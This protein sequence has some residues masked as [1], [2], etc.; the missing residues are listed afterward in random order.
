MSPSS[1][2]SALAVRAGGLAIALAALA[3]CSATAPEHDPVEAVPPVNAAEQAKAE[4]DPRP[5][6][7]A[8]DEVH[9]CSLFT[10]DAL[11]DIGITKRPQR[12]TMSGASTCTLSQ[13]QVEPMYDLLVIAVTDLGANAWLSG[14][15]ARPGT[16]TAVP[17]TMSGQ[18]AV[19]VFPSSKP[20]DEC[21]VVVDA[22]QG[23]SLQI[24]FG[25]TYR[26]RFPHAL[27]CELS[28]KAAA[29]AVEALRQNG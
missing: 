19:V 22:A 27:A 12:G 29:T 18:P 10:E 9:P 8:I 21:E 5:S 28:K 4:L 15:K 2:A 16:M 23:Q 17:S 26:G 13:E 6:D 3:G 14:N 7:L 20:A 25:T 24:R 1:P 11:N